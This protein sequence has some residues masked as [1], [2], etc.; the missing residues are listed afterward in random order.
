MRCDVASV[1][2]VK[3]AAEDPPSF[4]WTTRRAQAESRPFEV[5]VAARGRVASLHET[6]C[7]LRDVMRAA[8]LIVVFVFACDGSSDGSP[9]EPSEMPSTANSASSNQQDQQDDHD[10]QDDRDSNGTESYVELVVL[11]DRRVA[12]DAFE[13]A[14][15]ARAVQTRRTAARSLARLHDIAAVTL[16]R[17]ALRDP[18][19]EVRRHAALGLGGLE[20]AAPPEAERALLTALA[21]EELVD[22]RAAQL[23]DLGRIAGA[24]ALGAFRDAIAADEPMLREGACRGLGAYGLR[25]RP[26]PGALLRRVASRARDD[27]NRAVRLACAYALTRIDPPEGTDREAIKGDLVHALEDP[28]PE[29]RAMATRA[30]AAYGPAAAAL[31]ARTADADWQ[32]SVQAFRA[33]GR[34]VGLDRGQRAAEALRGSLARALADDRV[35]ST[36]AHVLMTALGALEAEARSPRVF[37]VSRETMDRLSATAEGE[38]VSRARGLVHCR[39]A[40]LYDRGRGWPGAVADC[41]LGQ[42]GRNEQRLLEVGV[43]AASDGAD[44]QRA[45]YLRR[46]HREGDSSVRQAVLGAMA[47]VLVPELWTLVLEGLAAEDDVGVVIAACDA[48]VALASVWAETANVDTPVLSVRAPGTPGP[49]AALAHR[50]GPALG[51]IHR[52]LAAAGETLVTGD[53]LEGLQSWLRAVRTI[54]DRGFLE[55]LRVLAGH[56]NPTVRAL[57][58]DVLGRQSDEDPPEVRSI[59]NVILPS[60]V[61]TRNSRVVFVTDAGT[62]TVELEAEAAPTTVARFV[63]LARDGYFDGLLFH[64]VVPAFVVQGGDPRGD[65]YGGPGWS[66][67][68]EDNRLRYER[69]TLGMALA[70]RDTGGSQFFIAHGPQ[71]HLDGRYTAFGHVVD[72]I[73]HLDNL[74]VGAR[75]ERVRLLD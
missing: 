25:D 43:I 61:P 32:V 75:I 72:G 62:I 36:E 68:C 26:L 56:A 18:D 29:V 51:A 14:L 10:Q 16:L 34:E 28:A 7:K 59:S 12:P 46:L 11:A 22:N 70:G 69:G 63:A 48:V 57:A 42:V 58:L 38:P 53:D 60:D 30:L 40:A 44:A 65:G 73:D 52:G 20:D 45:V 39:A 67:R 41:G 21:A 1:F 50:R 5:R 31:A 35:S 55:R 27:Q 9:S 66:Q 23:W 2:H 13:S 47:T 3:R 37:A 49:R 24:G 15:R 4:L 17:R 54:G 8:F 19:A 6:G 33:L 64:R 74:L 71:P